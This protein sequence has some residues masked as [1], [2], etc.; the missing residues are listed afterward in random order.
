MTYMKSIWLYQINWGCDKC[1]KLVKFIRN[2]GTSACNLCLYDI[3][4][5]WSKKNELQ[6]HV[7]KF[8]LKR[9]HLIP[10]FVYFSGK[11]R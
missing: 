2:S 1:K 3:D 6:S 8:L 10:I 9:N 7:S 5:P 11:L 4:F